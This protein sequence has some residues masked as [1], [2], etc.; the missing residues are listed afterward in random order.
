MVSLI[1]SS[2]DIHQVICKV[3]HCILVETTAHDLMDT[4]PTIR[5][6]LATVL[7]TY[8]RG[9]FPK[10]IRTRIMIMLCDIVLDNKLYTAYGEHQF[11][12]WLSTLPKLLCQPYISMHT[13]K[14]FSHLARQKNPHF[15]KH[16]DVN[17]M[18]IIGK[19][20][21]MFIG[22]RTW[23]GTDFFLSFTPISYIF[24]HTLCLY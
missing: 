10:E 5:T 6:L 13:L 14:T 20:F 7:E 17:Q 16:L 15:M 18:A 23:S 12:N 4:M 11:T 1:A 24:F 9:L 19:S 8:Q 2:S 22:W 3:L 21:L